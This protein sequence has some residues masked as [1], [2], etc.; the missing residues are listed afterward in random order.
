[1]ENFFNKNT[2]L[3]KLI[4]YNTFSKWLEHIT[5]KCCSRLTK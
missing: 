5:S 3:L 4:K 1:M 2:N